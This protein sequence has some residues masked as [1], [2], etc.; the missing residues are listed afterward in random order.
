MNVISLHDPDRLL[1]LNYVR[2]D[3]RDAV[4]ALWAL[5]EI[6]GRIVASTT[7]P[8]I[9]Q[10]R[11]TWWYER[12]CALDDGDCAAEPVLAALLAH[13][14][15]HDATGLALA[16]LVEGW[17]ALLETPLTDADLRTHGEHRGSHLFTLSAALIGGDLGA[18]AG[19]CWAL[20]DFARHCA[21]RDLADRA[22]ALATDGGNPR[23]LA[24]PLRVLSWLARYDVI[25]G[26]RRPRPRWSVLRAALA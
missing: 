21:T 7:Q 12:L 9:G 4:R 3:R 2:A 14:L 17:E 26:V 13:V 8:I 18:L 1:A 15:P 20:A 6:L 25:H 10:M 23:T 5:D 16:G 11:L 19:R 24:K 22:L